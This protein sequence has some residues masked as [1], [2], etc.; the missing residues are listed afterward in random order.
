MITYYGSKSKLIDLYPKPLHNLIIEPFAGSAR[1]ALKYFENDILLVD[2]YEVIIKIWHWL[3]QCSPNDILSLPNLTKGLKLDSLNLSEGERLF[4][5][6]IAGVSSTSPRNTVSAFSAEQNGRKNYYK[7]IA[8][9]LFK[10]KHWKVIHGSYADILNKTAT[11]FI[12]PPYQKGGHAYKENK[13]NFESLALWCKNRD[14]QTIVCENMNATWLPFLPIKYSRG[15]NQIYQTEAIW[16]NMNS[17]YE[18]VQ[19]ELFEN[20]P[21]PVK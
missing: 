21:N 14:G 16:T 2:K 9:Q 17:Q 7:R 4:L 1:Y 15:S 13:I 11:W 19:T 5:G 20:I 18:T 8:E 12:D 6:M 10:I 3:Q